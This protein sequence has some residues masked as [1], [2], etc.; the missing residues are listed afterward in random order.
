MII[1]TARSDRTDTIQE[2][3]FQAADLCNRLDVGIDLTIG[4]HLVEVRRGNHP[5][6]LVQQYERAV[7]AA[8]VSRAPE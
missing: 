7:R 6:N 8:S 4:D 5:H 2:T 3:C 1:F